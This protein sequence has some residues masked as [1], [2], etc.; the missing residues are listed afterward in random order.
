M[1]K[2]VLYSLLLLIGIITVKLHPQHEADPADKRQNL[3]YHLDIEGAI[4]PSDAEYFKQGLEEAVKNKVSTLLLTLNTPGGLVSSMRDINSAILNSEIPVVTYVYPEGARA[5][6][7]GTYML[8][9][10]HIAAMA[11]TTSLGAA[12]PVQIKGS[13]SNRVSPFSQ[14]TEKKEK[15]KQNAPSNEES[16]RKKQLNDSIAYIRSLA[17]KR[18]RNA[19]W[20][21][22]AVREA[23]TL[24]AGQALK[25]NVITLVAVDIDDLLK[26]ING[27]KTTVK[28]EPVTIE[29][30]NAEI[31]KYEKD[32]RTQFLD[33]ITDPNLAYIFMLIGIYGLIFE[34]SNPGIGLAG[35]AGGISLIIAMYSLQML[36]VNFAGLALILFGITLMSAE[37]FTPSFGILGL[38]GVVALVFGSIILFDTESPQ[39]RVA[40][41]IIA[42]VAAASFGFL[43]L[44]LGMLIRARKSKPFNDDSN[45][46]GRIA[47]VT[48]NGY[49]KIAGEL[50]RAEP[51]DDV[52][53]IKGDHVTIDRVDGLTVHVTKNED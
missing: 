31:I 10:S 2:P 8:Y 12:T 37:A 27:T 15:G 43:V 5:A 34:F 46:I 21:E 47:T 20:A 26:Q 33:I 29:T 41:Y 38:G 6:S 45:M 19:D 1:N 53:L 51:A 40:W 23:E 42:A 50:W 52:E 44:T 24:T 36:P 4:G 35:I 49:V 11:P 25:K 48:D 22:A 13:V 16:L 39:F 9:A 17:E 28:S 7:A 14:S 18:G 32:L 3:V 30:E